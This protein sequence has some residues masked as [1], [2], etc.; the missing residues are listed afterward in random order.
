MSVAAHQWK[1]DGRLSQS[2]LCSLFACRGPDVAS[3]EKAEAVR[4]GVARRGMTVTAM[5]SQGKYLG[6]SE[7]TSL[8]SPAGTRRGSGGGVGAGGRGCTSHVASRRVIATAMR[9]YAKC[10][11]LC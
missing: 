1:I 9:S 11:L 3:R 7:G 10:V 5:R 8:E 2:V 4:L 6:V